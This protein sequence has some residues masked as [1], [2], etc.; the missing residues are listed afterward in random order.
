MYFVAE[1][2]NT[3]GNCYIVHYMGHT[4]NEVEHA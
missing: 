4:D 3:Y 1:R 2:N